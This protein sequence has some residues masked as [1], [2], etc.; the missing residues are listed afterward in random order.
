MGPRSEI[1]HTFG[2]QPQTPSCPRDFENTQY[3]FGC[4]A[5]LL[6]GTGIVALLKKS[7]GLVGES[8]KLKAIQEKVE[9]MTDILVAKVRGRM[10]F[11]PGM[12]IE[13]CIIERA[14]YQF[15]SAAVSDAGQL[16]KVV[17]VHA[18]CE[19]RLQAAEVVQTALE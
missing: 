14:G 18:I 6:S 12:A 5:G 9:R 17:L 10:Q 3:N 7:R 15:W 16:Y 2:K 8:K 11:R 13:S 19:T 4:W 1:H